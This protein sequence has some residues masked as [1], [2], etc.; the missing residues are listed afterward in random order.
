LPTRTQAF[1]GGLHDWVGVAPPTKE[2]VA[3][4]PLVAFGTMHVKAIRETGG[5]IIGNVP[6]TESRSEIPELMD[7]HG[8]PAAYILKGVRYHRAARREEWG[9]VPVLRHWG[10]NVIKLLAESRFASSAP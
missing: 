2:D 1:F 4:A 8:G 6:L 3:N 10:Y 9:K 7:S 5:E